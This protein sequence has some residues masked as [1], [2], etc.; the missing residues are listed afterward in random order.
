MADM[1]ITVYRLPKTERDRWATLL[2]PY[3][4]ELLAQMDKS[5]AD[6]LRNITKELDSKYPYKE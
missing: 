1:G 6:K 3:A 2:K 4:E 5:T